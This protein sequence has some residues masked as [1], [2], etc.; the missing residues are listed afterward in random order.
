MMRQVLREFPMGHEIR[1]LPAE[2]VPSRNWLP[3]TAVHL[4]SALCEVHPLP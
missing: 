4:P 3:I 1:I 2:S